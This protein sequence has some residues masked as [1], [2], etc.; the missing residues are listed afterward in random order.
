MLHRHETYSGR[1]Q[2]LR[3]MQ[4]PWPLR[5]GYRG[6]GLAKAQGLSE[7][8]QH[9]PTGVERGREGASTP[10][11]AEAVPISDPRIRAPKA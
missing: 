6:E 11:S 9:C 2:R 8:E 7:I 3:R 1:V 5:R 4:T 10:D